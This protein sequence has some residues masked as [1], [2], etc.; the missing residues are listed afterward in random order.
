METCM[1]GF[2]ALCWNLAAFS[3]SYFFTQSVGL[4]GQGIRP[5]QGR[6]LHTGQ[7]KH[8][9][10]AHTHPF[11]KWDSNPRSQCL[12]GRRQFMP[13]T[14]WP[15]WSAIW[16]HTS[17]IQNFGFNFWPHILCSNRRTAERAVETDW[18]ERIIALLS[19]RVA[20]T[21]CVSFEVGLLIILYMNW[22]MNSVSVVRKRTIPTERP[23][24]VSEVSANL[25]G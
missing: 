2:T 16:R 6:Y 3:D 25:C 20:S 10:T 7:H 11:L 23:P 18:R 15:L 8:R 17:T 21:Q 19:M 24:L 14:A 1:Y 12:S 9:I 4:L 22:T 13:Q 5:S